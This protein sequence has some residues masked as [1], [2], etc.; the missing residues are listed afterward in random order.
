MSYTLRNLLIA[1]ALGLLGILLTTSYIV[2]QKQ[3]LERGKQDVLVIIAKKDIPAGTEASTLDDGGFIE[4]S[5]VL[6]EDVPPQ[7]IGSI[8]DVKKLALYETVYKGE[9]LTAHKFEATSSL[10]PAEQI[11]GNERL[12]SVEVPPNGRVADFIKPGDKVDIVASGKYRIVDVNPKNK[13]T[14]QVNCTFLVGRD[15][16]V[17][18][19]P[20]SL[21]PKGGEKVPAQALKAGD[22]P[23]LYVIQASDET[24]QNILWA[25]STAIESELMFMLRP[26][27]GSQETKLPPLCTL[28]NV[29]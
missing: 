9:V 6:R 10:N 5:R 18:Q 19:T 4:E 8:K 22:D 11:K 13:S 27:D 2:N 1:A 17:N 20:T 21:A 7:A 3:R 28:P 26:G 12:L 15:V 14:D 16:L 24:M 23:A 29:T 25:Q